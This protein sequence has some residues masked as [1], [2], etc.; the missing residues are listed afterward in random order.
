[1]NNDDKQKRK[2]MRSVQLDEPLMRIPPFVNENI[3][4]FRKKLQGR[5][6]SPH[7]E[8]PD[9][10][11]LWELS[12]KGRGIKVALLDSGA[13]INH[14]ALLNSIDGMENFTGGPRHDVTDEVGH[15][16]MVAGVIAARDPAGK[17][18]G[19]APEAKL[20][21]GKVI[22]HADKG[23]VGELKLGIEWAVENRVDVINI[24]LGSAM[25]L[26]S[27]EEEIKAA[28]DA[29]IFVVC[30]AGNDGIAGV[31]FPAKYEECIAVGAVKRN[32]VRW[33]DSG[34]G[35]SAIGDELDLMALGHQVPSTSIDHDGVSVNSGTSLAAPYVTG[36]LALGLVVHRERHGDSP[37]HDRRKLR[38]HLERTA[39]DLPIPKPDG[40]EKFHGHGLI[41]PKAFI[42]AI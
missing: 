25:S 5:E 11:R 7:L 39:I 3:K 2:R 14:P 17:L 32:N 19:V 27:I 9:L 36:L 30:A 31:D 34:G 40:V 16:T 18:L 13:K 28:H 33:K 12:K 1:M 29:K 38:E 21:I 20:Y 24:S 35:S 37:N 4:V 6:P 22:K 8:W 15:G 41:N 42:D 26:D 23:K 10:P